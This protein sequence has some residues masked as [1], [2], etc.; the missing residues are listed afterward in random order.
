MRQSY[1]SDIYWQ[2]FFFFILKLLV[3]PS[4]SSLEYASTNLLCFSTK[5][6]IPIYPCK[7]YCINSELELYVWIGEPKSS[8]FA[9]R[10]WPSNGLTLFRQMMKA[11]STDA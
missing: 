6:I 11:R 7:L 4:Q 10:R 2:K 5:I 8:A 9:F 3:M 1:Y